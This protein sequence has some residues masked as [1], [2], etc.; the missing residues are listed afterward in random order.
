MGVGGAG[1]TGCGWAGFGWVGSGFGGWGLFARVGF[2]VGAV[3]ALKALEG[4]GLEAKQPIHGAIQEVAVVGDHHH[5]TAKI[6]EEVLEHAQ[7]VDVEVVGGF[8]QQQHVG[9]FDQEPAQ[10]QAPPLTAREF[11][12]GLVLLGW[13]EQ[14][15]LEQLGGIEFHP[16]HR[17]AAGGIGDHVDHL[18]LRLEQHIA[19]LVEVG[20]FHGGTKLQTAA[21]GLPAPG[22]HLQQARFARPIG[23]NDADAIFGAEVVTELAQQ[24]FLL[25]ALANADA[26]VFGRDGAFAQA[27]AGRGQAD[28]TLDLA[29]GGLLHRLN[30]LDAG[31]LLGAPGLGTLFQPFQFPAQGALE[32]GG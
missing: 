1:W 3:V 7:G 9:R 26:E 13:R 17:H 23:A 2:E 16:I 6:F 10:M 8:I 25:L 27:A 14:E 30:P 24:G 4:S 19:V 20:Q 11:A 5:A 21:G 28:L 32:L 29:Q 22:D 15:A 12:H 31:F 18:A